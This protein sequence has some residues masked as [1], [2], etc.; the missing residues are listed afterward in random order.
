MN[1]EKLETGLDTLQITQSKVQGLKD[2]LDVKM[3]EVGEKQRDTNAL[4]E[5]VTAA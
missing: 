2:D 4:I 1:I 3:V 5:K